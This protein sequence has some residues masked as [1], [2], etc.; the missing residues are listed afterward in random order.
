MNAHTKISLSD[1]RI[2]IPKEYPMSTEESGHL[3]H[4]GDGVNKN[5]EEAYV[6]Y[7]IAQCAGNRSVDSIVSHL[8]SKLMTSTC[9]K[10]S[11]RAL[12]I[13]TRALTH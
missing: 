12:H 3:Y 13:Y 8:G 2:M 4:P 10:L 9:H 7:R 6:W 1:V 5:V 11:S